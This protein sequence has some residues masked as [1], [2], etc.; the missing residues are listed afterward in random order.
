MKERNTGRG[1]QEENSSSPR[2]NKLE[3]FKV[4]EIIKRGAFG[5]R[6]KVL[7]S[8]GISL[9]L[10]EEVLFKHHIEEGSVFSREEIRLLEE[11]SLYLECER[12]AFDLLSRSSYSSARLKLKLL[13]R[14]FPEMIVDKTIERM[15]ELG[16][17]NDEKFA[18][19]WIESR[20]KRHPE[21]RMALVA[22]LIDRGIE[23]NMAE[24]K[25]NELFPI[26]K[27]EKVAEEVYKRLIKRVF[28]EYSPDR[29]EEK[30]RDRR[31]YSRLNRFGFSPSVMVKLVERY[32]NEIKRMES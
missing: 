10:L 28:D 21:G 20:V 18:G 9:F 27:E 25:V 22:G 5:K 32:R 1:V 15:N 13:S 14:N 31:F 23:R 6:Y 11:E 8:G 2:G 19:D 12:K 30:N 29:G 17:I 24:R 7:F 26:E 3:N 16:Y 4:I